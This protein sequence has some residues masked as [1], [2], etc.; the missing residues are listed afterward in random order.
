MQL[1]DVIEQVWKCT[2]RP[3]SREL[4]N[5]LAG[6]C[7][8]SLEMHLEAEI[9][10]TQRCN[11]S[12]WS[13]GFGDALGDRDSEMSEM[14]LEAIIERVW[15]YTGPWSIE[16]GEVLGPGLSGGSGSGRRPDGSW[17]TIHWSTC[18]CWYVQNGVQQGAPRERWDR[19]E[20]GDSRSWD[21]V[22][23]SVCCTQCEL[24]IMVWRNRD[25]WLD[26]AFLGDGRV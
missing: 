15:R 23:L 21:D 11:Y 6:C 2:Q 3:R 12:L 17:H 5:A 19:L 14:Y 13:N 18:N 1:D 22:V 20:A 7:R 4:S 24:M 8:V 25:G 10:R 26:F 16:I 9:E